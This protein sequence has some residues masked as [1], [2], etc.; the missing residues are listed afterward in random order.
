MKGMI[1]ALGLLLSLALPVWAQA[2]EDDFDASCRQS[3]ME[4]EIPE[5]ELEDFVESC[6]QE[7]VDREPM[8][9]DAPDQG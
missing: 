7:M 4:Q 5:T 9:A 6:I 8:P 1:V 2:N 3:A